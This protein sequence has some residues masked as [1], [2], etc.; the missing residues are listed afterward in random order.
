MFSVVHIFIGHFAIT[1]APTQ[2]HKDISDSMTLPNEYCYSDHK[3]ARERT[4]KPK[5]STKEK[6]M[7]LDYS[8]LAF[9]CIVSK[10]IIYFRFEISRHEMRFFILVIV[11]VR[12]TIFSSHRSTR[13]MLDWSVDESRRAGA[14]EGNWTAKR[15]QNI[16]V[17]WP[18]AIGF[19]VACDICE[20]EINETNVFE[21]KTKLKISQ[22]TRKRDEVKKA[23]QKF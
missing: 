13:W 3:R 21:R 16:E 7:R 11:V 2:T 19:V 12:S 5:K 8:G 15:F 17:L 10:M 23:K 14:R 6:R 9:C 20:L 22:R 4:K 18:N 1:F